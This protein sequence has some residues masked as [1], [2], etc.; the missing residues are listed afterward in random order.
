M[1]KFKYI[2]LEQWT[3]LFQNIKDNLFPY[4]SQSRERKPE[5]YTSAGALSRCG[6]TLSL[7]VCLSV[8]MLAV[9]VYAGNG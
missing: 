3:L 8:E 7:C 4:E 2:F 6:D 9:N 1:C 5:S